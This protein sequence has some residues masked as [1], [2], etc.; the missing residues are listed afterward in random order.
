MAAEAKGVQ[1]I[2]TKQA[3]GFAEIVK[4]A[5]GDTNDA[6][7]LLIADKLEEIVKIQVE[8]IKNLKIDKVT[9]W[10]G[11][12]GKDGSPTTANFLSGMLKSIPPMNEMFK[13]AGM[14]LPTFLGKDLDNLDEAVAAENTVTVEKTE[15]K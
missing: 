2:L 7:K 9:V 15:E 11:M 6:V 3:A 1:E 4:S 12:G 10:D 14:E 13:M 5:G 8:A